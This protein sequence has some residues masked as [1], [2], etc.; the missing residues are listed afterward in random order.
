M[1]TIKEYW[2][3]DPDETNEDIL[4]YKIQMLKIEGET[5]IMNAEMSLMHAKTE[6]DKF[7]TASKD[8]PSVSFDNIAEHN[9]CI[10]A[11]ET[12]LSDT[13]STYNSLFK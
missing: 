3:Q 13:Q 5:A 1:K 7:I 10:K 8:A 11:A 9:Q 6:R 12:T 2:S 4:N